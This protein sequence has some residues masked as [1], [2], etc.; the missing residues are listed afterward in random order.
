MHRHPV[1]LISV[2]SL[3]SAAAC[4][5][6]TAPPK[7]PA[8]TRAQA[9]DASLDRSRR[10][11]VFDRY[12]A[13]GTSISMGW[14]SDGVIA[15]TQATSWPAQLALMGHQLITQPY[16]EGSGCR[17]PLK[18][19]LSSF[20][21]LSGESA[22]LPTDQLS[23]SPLFP[24]VV[25]PVQ[26][27]AINAA[28]TRDALYTTPENT[29]DASNRQLIGRVLEPGMT[30]VSS[31]VAQQPTLV[32]VE[33]GGNEV[34]NARNGVAIEGVSM[35]PY[36]L[37]E[38][39]Y[40]A[41][42]DRVSSV[43]DKAVIV[44][45]I[46]DVATFPAF[47][48]GDELWA[49]RAQFLAAF[50]VAVDPDCAADAN[51]DNLLFVPVVVPTAVAT[52]AA[53]KQNNLGPY[54]LHCAAGGA[55][56][57]DYILTPDEARTVNDL[58]GRMNAHIQQQSTERQF[59]YFALQAL[60]GRPDIKGT[61]DVVGLMTSLQPYGP[62]ISLDGVHPTTAGAFV[63]ASAAAHALDSSYGLHILPGD[64]PLV[65]SR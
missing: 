41:V 54:T 11:D 14:R 7:H 13:I 37:W 55:T 48:R 21:R 31:M 51:R 49:Q 25:K 4:S 3:M 19:P 40:D 32:S 45:L 33:L 16:I 38:Q 62:Y 26:N 39:L 30:Q 6:T 52:G 20:V 43:T 63:L 64:V 2:L 17:S 42:L 57:Q 44:G 15:A 29:T 60:Y 18:A 65:A 56:T 58:L 27:L 22:G 28:I 34:L 61:F 46:D 59:A 23:C 47:R 36:S 9:D 53:Y 1:V 8:V 10:H 5:D 12:V 50:N 35:F 24:G